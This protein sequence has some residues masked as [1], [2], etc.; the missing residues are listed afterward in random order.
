MSRG[1]QVNSTAERQPLLT[2]QT[3]REAS[4]EDSRRS[5]SCD[6]QSADRPDGDASNA[7]NTQPTIRQLL[8]PAAL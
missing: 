6:E 2:P 8:S 5:H 3:E 7:E 1:V 4:S